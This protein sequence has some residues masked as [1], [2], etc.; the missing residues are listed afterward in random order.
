MNYM[1]HYNIQLIDLPHEILLLISK[2]LTNIEVLYSLIGIHI[3][4][5]K[6]L[7]DRLFTE[8][9][10]LIR[11]RLTNGIIKLMDDSILDRFCSQI[12]PKTHHQ[13]K[14]FTFDSSSMKRILFSATYP[15][16]HQLSL[17]DIEYETIV[18][19]FGGKLF[20]LHIFIR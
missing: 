7:S 18:R 19:V 6:I 15:H 1:Q 8:H 14:S 2:N 9:L 20:H 10:I 5:D 11:E 13:I 17:F 12:I 4:F 16:L 3:Q